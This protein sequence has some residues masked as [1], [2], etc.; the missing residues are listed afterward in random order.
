MTR[1]SWLSAGVLV[2][3]LAP[4]AAGQSVDPKGTFVSALGRFSLALD[5]NY[6]DEDETIRSSLDAMEGALNAWDAVIRTYEAAIAAGTGGADAEL[7]ARMRTALAGVYLDRQRVDAALQELLAARARDPNR[8][9]VHT[10]L[11]LVYSQ[12]ADDQEAATEAFRRAATLEPDNPIR[13]Y[14]LA[15][16]LG[17]QGNAEESSAALRA[18]LEHRA[19][20]DA[21]QSRTAVPAPF[22]R[23]ALVPESAGVEP[24]FP[25]VRYAAGF[26]A[27]ARGEY[28]RAIA[29]FREAAAKDPL[30]VEA[31]P[32][33]DAM[34]RAA[35]EFR[36]GSVAGALEQL[37]LAVTLAPDRAEPHRIRGLVHAADERHDEA[38][39]AF[40]RAI[41]LDPRDER[42]RLA[43][44]R[45]LEDAGLFERAHEALRETLT[46][47]TGSGRARYALAR[48]HQREGKPTDALREFEAAVTYKPLLGLNGIY[49]TM[50]GLHAPRQNFDAALAAYSRRAEVHPN[51]PDAHYDLGDIYLRQGRHDEAL[52]ELSVVLLLEPAHV[53]AAALMAQA[54]LRNADYDE[55]VAAARRA[56]DADPAQSEARYVLATALLRLGRAD[57]GKKELETFQRQQAETA[58]SRARLLEVQ[59]LRRDA[60]VSAADGDHARTVANLRKVLEL[61][62]SYV[63]R[64][65]LGL[66]LLDADQPAEALEHLDAA[67][68]DLDATYDVHRYLSAAYLALGRVADSQREQAA[69]DRIRREALKRRA[70]Q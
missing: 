61:E 30:V 58:A 15:R 11:G 28:A 20:R 50:G 12:L 27:L 45:A 44:V 13:T 60:A 63:S 29:V 9:D 17:T 32:H 54:H 21:V 38:A 65:E 3:L 24:Y 16:Q 46:V 10:L 7:A 39:A 51:D 22:I 55:A 56:L 68:R 31:G 36:E 5:G 26:E 19:T 64:L 59:G 41:S 66:A 25:P 43:L 34:Q 8:P 69:Y 14:V 42:A 4:P 70:A 52:A 57:E 49:E 62:T 23:L 35:K 53:K 47:L 6:G 48:L 40:Q 37:E 67:A 2:L 18:F 1:H 33:R